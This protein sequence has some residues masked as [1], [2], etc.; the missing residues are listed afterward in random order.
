MD[1]DFV[2]AVN[3]YPYINT[4]PDQL[5]CDGR[6]LSTQQYPALFSLI[7]NSYGGD[8]TETFALPNLLGLEPIP[9]THYYIVKDGIYPPRS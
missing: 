2:G 9:Y 4:P 5:L 7:L 3:L 8:G 6:I 1:D